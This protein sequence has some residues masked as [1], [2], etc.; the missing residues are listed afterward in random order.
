[1]LANDGS[2]SFAPAGKFGGLY[3]AL[4]LSAADQNGDGRM[5]LVS[6]HGSSAVMVLFGQGKGITPY[7]C[8]VNPPGSLG[9]LAGSPTLG[10]LLTLGVDNPLGTQTPGAFT[11]LALAFAP[12]PAFP[13]G[14]LLPGFGMAGPGALG[15]VLLSLV[16]S[17]LLLA[18]PPF[19]GSG[20]PSAFALP[21][22]GDGALAGVL[23][24]AQGAIVDPAGA[25]AVGLTDG[26][27]IELGS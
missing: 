1:L 16:P 6:A 13:C 8:A 14:T 5:D 10:T 12:D 23:V 7:G 19:A 17:P 21:I 4:E 26:L 20:I 15:E 2:G 9:V 18:G 3:G 22:P 25:T 24:F 27:R 11:L